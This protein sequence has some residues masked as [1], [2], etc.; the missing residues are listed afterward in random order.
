MVEV[1]SSWQQEYDFMMAQTL[2]DLHSQSNEQVHLYQL[3]L[4]QT[5]Q[6]KLDN[7][8]LSSEQNDKAVSTAREEVKEARMLVVSLSYQ[9]SGLQNQA[10][11]AEDYIRELEEALAGERDKFRKMLDT[12][13]KETTEVRHVAAAGG[14]PGDKRLLQ[15]AGGWRVRRRGLSCPTTLQQGL[16]SL[17]PPGEAAAAGL[18]CPW[19][20]A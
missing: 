11:A 8:K 10:S 20:G 5:Y 16:P 1:D 13:E 19:G 18:A 17:R 6:A 4:E 14:V 3:G 9:F 12:K 2:E 7:T 15:A